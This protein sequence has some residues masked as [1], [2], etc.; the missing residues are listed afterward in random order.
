MMERYGREEYRKVYSGSGLQVLPTSR[1]WLLN[2]TIA[3]YVM[4]RTFDVPVSLTRGRPLLTL[5]TENISLALRNLRLFHDP[6]RVALLGQDAPRSGEN[7][8]SRS[9]GT[10][11]WDDG[12]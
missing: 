6:Y 9:G 7:R 12:A 3:D 4:K 2:R 5:P 8:S 10:A 11:C 1:A